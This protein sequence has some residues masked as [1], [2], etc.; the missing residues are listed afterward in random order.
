ME[1]LAPND[2]K[3]L[4]DFGLQQDIEIYLQPGATDSVHKIWPAETEEQLQLPAYGL[5]VGNALSSDGFY[6]G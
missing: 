4:T 2:V 6:A 3:A 1:S 5:S